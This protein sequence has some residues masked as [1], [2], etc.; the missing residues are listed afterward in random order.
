MKTFGIVLSKTASVVFI[1]PVIALASVGYGLTELVVGKI[2][3]KH[4]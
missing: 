2:S 4:R 1:V 3:Q